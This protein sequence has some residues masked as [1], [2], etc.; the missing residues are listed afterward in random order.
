[1]KLLLRAYDALIEG[2]LTVA[3]LTMLAVCLLIVSDVVMRNVGLPPPDSTVALTEYSLLYVTM[4]AAPALVRGRGHIVVQLLHRRLGDGARRR[5][6]GAILGACATIA[7]AIAG[8]AL[9]LAIE[10]VRRGEIDVRSLDVSR[11]FLFA[12]IVVGFTLMAT[13]FIR[14]L[15]RGEGLVRPAGE[16]EIL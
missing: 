15:I 2:L 7:L 8:L 3:G 4:A 1:M 16:R 10:A 13:E 11:A 9:A 14:L 5:L 12:P 6:E